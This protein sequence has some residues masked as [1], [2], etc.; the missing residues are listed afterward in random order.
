M[1]RTRRLKA[2]LR[3]VAREACVSIATASMALN[4]KPGVSQETRIRVEEAAAR[5]GYGLTR[6]PHG[7][8]LAVWVPPPVVGSMGGAHFQSII[9]RGVSLASEERGFQSMYIATTYG[10]LGEPLPVPDLQDVDV[11]GIIIL[12]ATVGHLVHAGKT[13]KPV[14]LVDTYRQFPQVPSVDNDDEGGSYLAVRHLISLGHSSIAYIGSSTAHGIQTW[15]GFRR[16]MLEARLPIDPGMIEE[17]PWGPAHSHEAM[18]RILERGKRPTGLFCG[19]DELAYGAIRA[20]QESGLSVPDDV[21]VVAMDDIPFSESSSPPLTTVR[22]CIEEMGRKA[23]DILTRL[24]N[25]EELTSTQIVL[26]NEL[27]VR[28][29]CGAKLRE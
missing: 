2:S 26:K 3:D 6:R 11:E 9:L 7:K 21:A 24:I 13:R 5:L 25:G 1:E 4:N 19:G 14:V 10:S 22:I 23:V 12:A 27:V 29:S 16:A 8:C 17:V 18:L 15:Q 28:H 20:L